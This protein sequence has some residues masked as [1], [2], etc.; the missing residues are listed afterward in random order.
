VRFLPTAM[1]SL[2]CFAVIFEFLAFQLRAGNDPALG[3]G[4]TVANRQ[5]RQSVIERRIIQRRIVHLP[6]EPSGST[7][8]AP[9]APA[10]ATEPSIPA[11]PTA[12]VAPA[13]APAPAAPL[14]TSS[15]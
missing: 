9:V 11:A 15:S 12:P 10:P 8:L 2:A 5:S 6:P 13:P 14:V 3:D 7:T 1:A 4:T